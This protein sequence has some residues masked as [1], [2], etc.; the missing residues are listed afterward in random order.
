MSPPCPCGQNPVYADCCGRFHSGQARPERA[1]QLMRARYSA[2]ALQKI[3]YL[4]QT[5]HPDQRPASPE[6]LREWAETTQFQRL[7]VHSHSL[8][9]PGDKIGKVHFSAHYLHAGQAG[10]IE[11]ISRFRRWRGQWVYLDGQF[12]R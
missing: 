9:G 7:E 10:V 11:E 5:H 8:G 4:W 3:D 6:D 12:V 1:E 2:Y